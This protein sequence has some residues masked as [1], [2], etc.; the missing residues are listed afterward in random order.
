MKAFLQKLSSI[1]S[2]SGGSLD[3]IIHLGAGEFSEA[4]D[5][6]G[7]PYQ[8]LFLIEGDPDVA[9][10]LALH[11][12]DSSAATIV[13][14]LITPVATQ[15]VFHR[16]SLPFL[17]GPLAL[18]ELRRIYPRLQELEQ[19][20]REGV[21]LGSFL[22]S[23][24]VDTEHQS[25]LLI[26]DIPG[27]EGSI[28][29]SLSE[30]QLARFEWIL[31]RGA[32]E[33]LQPGAR[34]ITLTVSFLETQGFRA[35]DRDE[36]DPQWP[37][38]LLQRDPAASRLLR[39]IREQEQLILDLTQERH[40]LADALRD[41]EVVTSS[42]LEDRLATISELEER[43]AHQ[44]RNEANRI[45]ELEHRMSLLAGDMA[46]KDQQISEKD[47]LT[48]Q[49]LA[50]LS[51]LEAALV[52]H[53]SQI[54]VLTAQ[55]DEL[56][57]TLAVHQEELGNRDRLL[58]GK[59]TQIHQQGERIAELERVVAETNA[60]RDGLQGGVTELTRQLEETQSAL[61]SKQEELGNRDRLLVE[62][63]TEIHQ[64]GERIAELERVVGE[65]SAHRD[66]L[67]GELV[68]VRA[69]MEQSNQQLGAL[70]NQISDLES[71][72]SSKETLLDV[73]STGRVQ[74]DRMY[75]E[76]SEERDGLQKQIE[77]LEA[78]LSDLEGQI[79][80]RDGKSL[81][82]DA[83]FQKVEGQMEIIKEIFL[84]ER[85]K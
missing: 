44:Q 46:A 58:M 68:A 6:A 61:F 8:K 69:A 59:A 9:E 56:Q 31:L 49:Q 45:L 4:S 37:L 53:R 5:Y 77:T 36:S 11:H 34:A 3:Q 42:V 50:R 22:E 17:N 75:E 79:K 15:T 76:L 81:L 39:Q 52:E 35:I 38:L 19:L 63:A 10:K 80:D 25:S 57:G 24:P 18:G 27:Q 23:V 85:L 40:S 47:V 28:L 84:R 1:I 65:L 48:Q 21:T 33:S 41:Q 29:E 2:E 72:V 82:V 13:S 16:Y 20:H 54:D 12:G 71:E 14:S 60:Q 32:S 83:E 73:L 67:Q 26:L 78:R 64:Q 70:Q 66:A 30:D 51:E 7:L 55:R 74:Q 62:K 43:L